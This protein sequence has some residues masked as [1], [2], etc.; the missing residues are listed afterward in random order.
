MCRLMADQV[1]VRRHLRRVAC[2]PD[3]QTDAPPVTIPEV[4]PAEKSEDLG[5]TPPETDEES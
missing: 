4:K 5:K 1:P 2:L 3:T